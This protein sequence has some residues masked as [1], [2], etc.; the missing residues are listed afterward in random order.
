MVD[1]PKTVVST[2]VVPNPTTV[3]GLAGGEGLVLLPMEEWKQVLVRGLRTFFQVLLAMLL[4]K[5]AAVSLVAS[6]LP[7]ELLTGIPTTGILIVD[8][9][10]VGLIGFL[11]S[12]VWNIVEFLLDVDLS[13]PKFRA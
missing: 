11:G 1:Q 2:D 9:L 5:G 13:A 6:G 4:G 10:V 3:G 12:A 8:A 7:P